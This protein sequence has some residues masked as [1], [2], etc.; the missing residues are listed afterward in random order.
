MAVLRTRSCTRR[1]ECAARRQCQRGETSACLRSIDQR[2]TERC[3]IR[4]IKQVFHPRGQLVLLIG[5]NEDVCGEI[6]D[7]IVA[8]REPAEARRPCFRFA[9]PEHAGIPA[10]L[11]TQP[12]K[13][14]TAVAAG[15]TNKL[16]AAFDIGFGVGV[17][18]DGAKAIVEV[19]R[20]AQL[21]A[22]HFHSSR[23]VYVNAFVEVAG[24][25]IGKERR[26]I[27]GRYGSI[28]IREL[29]AVVDVACEVG[30]LPGNPGP[31][32]NSPPRP[33]L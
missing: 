22:A 6:C 5:V 21:E 33:T 17:A 18:G 15:N 8:I 20:A 27:R 12:R 26:A 7:D 2:R 4:L 3:A 24:V 14:T 11:Q 28:A 29:D 23:Q 31:M 30:D 1:A 19:D 25:Q 32:P 9:D 10:A 16:R 13:M